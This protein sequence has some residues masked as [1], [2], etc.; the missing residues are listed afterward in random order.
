[1]PITRPCTLG[2]SGAR[3]EAGEEGEAGE[4]KALEGHGRR[5]LQG[6]CKTAQA[7]AR[8]V[9]KNAEQERARDRA[10]LAAIQQGHIACMQRAAAAACG[11]AR[12]GVGQTQ[13]HWQKALEHTTRRQ[14]PCA[15]GGRKDATAG[16]SA[17]RDHCP[18]GP[19]HGGAEGR[20][21]AAAQRRATRRIEEKGKKKGGCH[22]SCLDSPPPAA[23]SAAAGK[24]PA[25]ASAANRRRPRQTAAQHAS[26]ECR[27][28]EKN[29]RKEA[30]TKEQLRSVTCSTP[31]AAFRPAAVESAWERRNVEQAMCAVCTQR[32]ERERR[33]TREQVAEN[34]RRRK[35]GDG[36]R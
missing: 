20:A 1:M 29:E 23:A 10:A 22:L 27:A 3:E 17:E 13:A 34:E 35:E 32:P 2:R 15:Q 14:G 16:A 26:E 18:L 11:T 8:A 12:D 21:S 31:A 7:A 24:T 9:A 19:L 36:K 4:A 5:R 25:A 30:E 6:Q 33:R 28:G